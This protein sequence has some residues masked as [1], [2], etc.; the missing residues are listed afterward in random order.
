MLQ[1]AKTHLQQSRISKFSG[2]GPPDP[3]LFKG[4]VGKGKGG[5]ERGRGNGREGGRGR[6]GKGG[7]GREGTGEGKREGGEEWGVVG[8]GGGGRSTWAP[9]RDKLW[10]C[11]CAYQRSSKCTVTYAA[12]HQYV[13]TG[14]RA[15]VQLLQVSM[16]SRH[17][18]SRGRGAVE[19]MSTPSSKHCLR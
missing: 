12:A 18:A 7:E 8:R 1:C 19:S 13:R 17:T 4:R 9:P 6:I 2:G 10:I 11:P 14:K 5:E 3:G 15:F 16:R